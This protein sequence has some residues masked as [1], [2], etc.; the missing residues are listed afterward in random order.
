MDDA[1]AVLVKRDW[2]HQEQYQQHYENH[3]PLAHQGG[4]R[5]AKR[6]CQAATFSRQQSPHKQEAA[7]DVPCS[8]MFG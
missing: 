1:N 6:Q 5:P 7:S 8:M 4:M 3:D 2:N